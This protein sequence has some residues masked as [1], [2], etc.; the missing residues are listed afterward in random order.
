MTKPK[1]DRYFLI[2]DGDTIQYSR[3]FKTPEE[4]VTYLNYLLEV[5]TDIDARIDN[6]EVKIL[7]VEVID[8]IKL[9]VD[10]IIKL[11][12]ELDEGKI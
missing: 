7:V 11:Q 2:L 12:S 3:M 1:K 4:A 8:S 5:H 9:F 6:G 10:K